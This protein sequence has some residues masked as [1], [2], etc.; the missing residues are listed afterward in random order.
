ML[1]SGGKRRWGV[2]VKADKRL[3][4]PQQ[5]TPA[6]YGSGQAY[7]P[8][9][10]PPGGV[11]AAPTPQQREFL[12]RMGEEMRTGVR[13]TGRFGAPQEYRFG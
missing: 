12:R 13:P 5:G 7:N 11:R 8:S 4:P 6:P 9:A 10:I 1:R 3:H 2:A